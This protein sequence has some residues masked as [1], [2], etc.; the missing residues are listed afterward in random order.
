MKATTTRRRFLA[1]SGW[2][3]IGFLL[4]SFTTIGLAGNRPA[5]PSNKPGD[6]TPVMRQGWL[7]NQDDL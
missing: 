7:L 3:G 6:S 2:A 1:N 4:F 5:P